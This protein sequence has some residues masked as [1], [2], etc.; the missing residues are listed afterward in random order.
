MS[1]NEL[2]AAVLTTLVAAALNWAFAYLKVQID[3]A[4]FNALVAAIVAALLALFGVQV[5]KARGVRGIR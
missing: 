3:V 1:W 2:I 4:T 5:L